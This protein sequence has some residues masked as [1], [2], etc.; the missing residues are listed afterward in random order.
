MKLT[1]RFCLSTLAWLL[2]LVSSCTKNEE[3]ATPRTQQ[4]VST[5]E[6]QL[7]KR[8]FVDRHYAQQLREDKQTWV[9]LWDQAT[10]PRTA[11]SSTTIYV[12][13]AS[14]RTGKAEPVTLVGF[15]KYLRIE[16]VG[17]T[18]T[19]SVALYLATHPKER[20]D[21]PRWAN[22]YQN[23]AFLTTFTG[24]RAL[25]ELTTG[26]SSVL[27]YQDGTPLPFRTRTATASKSATSQNS[28]TECAEY[29]TW[30]T[31]TLDCS[32]GGGP[33]SYIT[34]GLDTD[35]QAPPSLCTDAEWVRT[36]TETTYLC[37]AP[38]PVPAPVESKLRI[39][40]AYEILAP[41]LVQ[42]LKN[43]TS[44]VESNPK[45]LDGLM[46]FS[47]QTKEQI[48]YDLTYG[49]GPEIVIGQPTDNNGNPI[50][51]EF[52]GANPNVIT[53]D[54]AF[55]NQFE[56]TTSATASQALSFY[57]GVAVLHEYTHYGDYAT[58]NAFP[59]EEGTAFERTVFGVVVGEDNAGQ[60]KLNFINTP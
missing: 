6:I 60:V 1:V 40:P 28:N 15:K 51:G 59:G 41:K 21:L 27:D 12:P 49:V 25:K 35:C 31:W 37:P 9:P 48:L 36:S 23:P 42:T 22:W 13:L 43:L 10:Q 11:E 58:G 56:N 52:L 18:P 3:L 16:R 34:V 44:F 57:L 4:A 38:A 45:V 46:K 55:I 2:L 26:K 39:N 24:T 14:Y 30:C 5:A 17:T 50:L 33:I 20:L 32:D 29:N 7:L 19:F 8:A 54:G 53:L 47:N